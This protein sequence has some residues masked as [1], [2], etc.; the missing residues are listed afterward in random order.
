MPRRPVISSRRERRASEP[1]G[2]IRTKC[3]RAGW[4]GKLTRRELFHDAAYYSF[5]NQGRNTTM[6]TLPIASLAGG[7]V[8]SRVVHAIGMLFTTPP[9]RAIAMLV[10]HAS[11]VAAGEWLLWS[12]M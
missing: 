3:R 12:V 8:F 10:N 7:F 5:A 11:I 4:T 6:N 9:V 1:L 2:D